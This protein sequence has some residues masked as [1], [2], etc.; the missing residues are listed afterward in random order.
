ME[1][2]L[3]TEQEAKEIE[4]RVKTCRYALFSPSTATVDPKEVMQSLLRDCQETGVNIRTDTAYLGKNSHGLKTS[5]GKISPGFIINAAGLYADKIALDFGFSE[6]YRILPFKGVY[7]YG[8]A[9]EKL[10]TNIYPV[11]NLD[12]PFLGV[13]FT[14]TVDNKVKIGPTAIPAFWRE[15]YRGFKNFNLKESVE[16]MGRE[17][18]L[19][20]RNRFGFRD[21]A[22]KELQKYYRPKLVKLASK[23]ITGVKKENYTHWGE[24]G[25]RAQLLDL[26]KGKLEMDFKYEGDDHSFH[27]LNAV[28]P[29]F[30]CSMPL[31]EFMI[32]NLMI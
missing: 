29:A 28:S 8:N 1:L 10:K 24:P 19:F 12:N 31:G 30:T 9:G 20:L 15:N 16:I 32:D 17:A 25:I 5:Q 27:V 21:L 26:K 3:I 18:G 2:Q 14:V 7:L 6:R 4:P 11:P 22:F 23:M 13:H